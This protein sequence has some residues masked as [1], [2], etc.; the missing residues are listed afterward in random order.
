V[1]GRHD[2]E[3]DFEFT[4]A[5]EVYTTE[6]GVSTVEPVSTAGASVSTAGASLA[7]DKEERQRIARVQEDASSFNIEEYDEI[8]AR[9]E[10][11]EEFAHRL[12]SEERERYSE[13]EKTRLITELSNERKRHFAAQRA[14]ERRNKPL[15]QAQQRTYMSQYIKNIGSHTLK[16]MKSYSF[17]EIKNLFET[18]MRRVHTFVPMENETERVIPELAAGSSKRDAEEEIPKFSQ[19]RQKSYARDH[20]E[21]VQETTERIIQIKQRIQTAQDRQ[22]SYA[23]LKRKPMEF[24]V[25]DKCP[26]NFLGRYSCRLKGPK[27]EVFGRILSQ[28][29]IL[30]QETCDLFRGKSQV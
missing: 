14:K 24:Q 19:A 9:V 11:D 27:D 25:R 1:Q 21:L 3:S 29:K 4:T 8:Q 15:T 18:T 23:D 5:E 6:K 12:Q 13:A 30:I 20:P 28:N 2:R 26:E 17:N 7:K 16:Q 10:V 22:K